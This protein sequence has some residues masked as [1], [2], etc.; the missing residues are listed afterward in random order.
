MTD[1][2]KVGDRVEGQ[3]SHRTG[4]IYLE[5][6]TDRLM[7]SWDNGNCPQGVSYSALTRISPAVP[8]PKFRDGQDVLSPGGSVVK[9]IALGPAY[10][11]E[12]PDGTHT[13]W[14]EELLSPVPVPVCPTCGG[15]GVADG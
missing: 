8:Q 7:V 10:R 14:E 12:Y 5:K 1:E 4:T 6:E 9:I 11:V 2:L 15:K 3:G 13:W